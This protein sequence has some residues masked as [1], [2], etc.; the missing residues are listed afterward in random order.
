[1]KKDTTLT[2]REIKKAARLFVLISMA[3]GV[4][5]DGADGDTDREAMI[6]EVVYSA[7]DSLQKEFPMLEFL[8][9]SQSGCIDAIKGM[10]K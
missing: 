5:N 8:P 1:M 4:D 7:R 6:Y 9:T 10:R 3:Y 2:K